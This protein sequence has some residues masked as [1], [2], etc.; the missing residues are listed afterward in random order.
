MRYLLLPVTL[1][2]AF[3]CLPP[4]ASCAEHSAIAGVWRLDTASA[5][6]ID[7]KQITSGTLTIE[8]HH[9]MIQMSEALTFPGGDRSLSQN[10]KID[11]HYHPVLGDGSGQ[12]LAKWEGLTLTAD[13]ENSGTHENYRLSLSEDGQVLTE[14]IR[15]TDGSSAILTWR[16]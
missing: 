12:V 2:A 8:Y 13:H 7:G 9:K 14:T 16:R 10:W 3:L 6:P 1:S 11:S 5:P 4:A 15:H